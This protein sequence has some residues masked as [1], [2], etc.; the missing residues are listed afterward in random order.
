ML[1]ADY[2]TAQFVAQYLLHFLFCSGPAALFGVLHA[3]SCP[4]LSSG[5]GWHHCTL[6]NR[7]LLLSHQTAATAYAICC[8]LLL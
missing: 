8:L 3:S 1:Q 4:F 5:P 7:P 6:R 2:V